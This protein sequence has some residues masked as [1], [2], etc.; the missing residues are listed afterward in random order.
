MPSTCERR[1]KN[2]PLTAGDERA[3]FW[4]H[5]RAACAQG[6]YVEE[7]IEFKRQGLS[8]RTI[9]RLTGYDRKQSAGI[10]QSRRAGRC[11]VRE[12]RRQ[13]CWSLS[14]YL[15]ER[16][17]ADVWNAMVLLRE[18]RE[19]G[20]GG[21]DTILKDWL[22]PLSSGFATIRN[23]VCRPM[24]MVEMRMVGLPSLSYEE[25][26]GRLRPDHPFLRPADRE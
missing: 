1:C 9:S 24:Q 5:W 7:V 12:R 8:V 22:Y 15:K 4:M 16:F 14:R 19:R 23:D 6:R 20:Y 2:P 26:C 13:S 10:R 18:L 3:R 11:M 17:G 25:F 21:G